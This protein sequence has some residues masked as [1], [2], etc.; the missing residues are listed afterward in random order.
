MER[1]WGWSTFSDDDDARAWRRE[2]C[3]YAA[4]IPVTMAIG[5]FLPVT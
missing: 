2:A 1:L 5:W 4:L 3:L